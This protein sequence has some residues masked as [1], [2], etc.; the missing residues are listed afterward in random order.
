VPLSPQPTTVLQ[1]VVTSTAKNGT[2]TGTTSD[3][4]LV[5]VLASVTDANSALTEAA[6][7]VA[8]LSASDSGST[9]EDAFIAILAA[10]DAAQAVAETASARAVPT[11]TDASVPTADNAALAVAS[12]GSDVNGAITETVALALT[13]S[14][15]TPTAADTAT[16]GVPPTPITG[17]DSNGTTTENANE[18]AV[19]PAADASGTDTETA[20][21]TATSSAQDVNGT[22][23]EALQ[24]AVTG[25]ESAASTTPIVSD[26]FTRTVTP[27]WGTANIGGAYTRNQGTDS[28]WAVDGAVGTLT[29]SATGFEREQFLNSVS[30]ADIDLLVK[31]HLDAQPAGGSLS[32]AVRARRTAAGAN[33]YALRAIF[34]TAGTIDLRLERIT[35]TIAVQTTAI[36]AAN[37]TAGAWVWIRFRLVGSSLRARAWKDGTAEPSTWTHD[38]TDATFTAAG[39]VG[40]TGLRG[41]GNTNTPVIYVDELSGTDPNAVGS[42]TVENATTQQI[43]AVSGSDANSTPVEVGALTATAP[44]TDGGSDTE[45]GSTGITP[46]GTDSGTD[47]ET[48]TM[49]AKPAATEAGSGVDAGGTQNQQFVVGTDST[50]GAAQSASA[51]FPGASGSDSGVGADS[52]AQRVLWVVP[53]ANGVA[54]EAASTVAKAVAAE[55]GTS[56]EAVNLKVVSVTPDSGTDS[57]T[58]KIALTGSDASGTSTELT[59]VLFNIFGADFSSDIELAIVQIIGAIPPGAPHM[60]VAAVLGKPMI[61]LAD[62]EGSILT[63]TTVAKPILTGAEE[64]TAAL[65]SATLGTPRLR[66]AGKSG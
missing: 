13:G 5:S 25:S 32:V 39:G 31:V 61:L 53:D 62:S 3:S 41:S 29:P 60:I 2:D 15:A 38:I 23:A 4:G 17:T 54:L 55:T 30:A 34:T 47:S 40:F 9:Q 27:G 58:T 22:V 48:F 36:T 1:V 16:A 20:A 33:Y 57:E 10:I 11:V 26:T 28:E 43:T 52:G 66:K 14:D 50:P 18:S 7:L 64:E 45:T 24:L 35:T 49:T 44:G 59:S 51:A 46:V 12:P 8:L 56:L 42:N 6:N 65:T 37:M 63:A 21:L 19:I